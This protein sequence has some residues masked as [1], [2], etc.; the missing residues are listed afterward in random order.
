[1]PWLTVHITLP[2]IILS[3]WGLGKVIDRFRWDYLKERRG[4]VIAALLPVVLFSLLAALG[5]LIGTKPPFQGKDLEQLRATTT[6]VTAMVTFLVSGLAVSLLIRPWPSG[7]LARLLILVMAGFLGILTARAAYRAAY[8]NY[9]DATEYLVYAH[10]AGGVKEALAQIEELSR[11]T[12][13]GL[14]MP[15]AYDDATTYP[16]WWYL[17]NYTDQ[18]YYG[19]NPTRSLRDV[20][21]ILVG[22]PNYGKIEP[23]VGQAYYQFDYVRLWW[24]NQ[25]YFGLTWQRV[26]DTLLDPQMRTAVFDIW[27]NRDYK[28]YGEATGKDMSLPNWYPSARMRLYLRK[29]LV[30]QLWNYGTVP[31]AAEVV[32]D[33]YEGKGIQLNADQIFGTAGAAEG[34]FNRPR[35]IAVAPDGSLYVAD[36]ENNRIQHLDRDGAV[37]QSWGGFGDVSVAQVP[38]GLFNQ[39]WGIGVGPDGSVYVADTW[40]H[41]VQKFSPTGEFIKMWGFFGQAEAPEAFWGPRAIAVDQ[42]GRVFVTDTGNKRIVVFDQDGNFITQ[43][44]SVGLNLGEFDEP[45]GIA[46]GPGWTGLCGRYLEPAHS[47]L[48]RG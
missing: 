22:D 5:S 40:N 27:L 2:M 30:N 9:D 10:S 23:V 48:R 14:N 32:A 44:G 36:T 13:G 24:P 33:P 34:Q 19:A 37:L 4:W 45:V 16:Y 31:T 3:G 29:D 12:T 20:P 26:L 39:P 7:Q 1:M 46:V 28:A 38:G 8:I 42:D 47:G 17:R 25:D 41:R 15:V 21:A 11:R 43:F 6:F 18:R 35:G